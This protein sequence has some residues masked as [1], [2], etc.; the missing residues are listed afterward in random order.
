MTQPL[1]INVFYGFT[2]M[3]TS[4]VTTRNFTVHFLLI[5]ILT[6]GSSKKLKFILLALGGFL[7][8][9]GMKNKIYLLILTFLHNFILSS[10]SGFQGCNLQE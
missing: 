8:Y 6:N 2:P 4:K 10:S 9:F 1:K 3:I 7:N 5:L